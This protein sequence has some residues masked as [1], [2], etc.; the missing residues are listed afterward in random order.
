MTPQVQHFESLP[1][2]SWVALGFHLTPLGYILVSFLEAL[3]LSGPILAIRAICWK[4][5]ALSATELEPLWHP[6]F[7]HATSITKLKK[8]DKWVSRKPS[9]KKHH[10]TS[11]KVAQCG[12][13]D[14]ITI[15]FERSSHARFGGFVITVGYPFWNHAWSLKI[16]DT[17]KV[18]EKIYWG[19]AGGSVGG[20]CGPDKGYLKQTTTPHLP[21]PW[22]TGPQTQSPRPLNNRT[23]RPQTPFH[24]Q[25]TGGP[26]LPTCTTTYIIKRQAEIGCMWLTQPPTRHIKEILK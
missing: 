25:E 18:I 11:P 19:H 3:E 10:P 17:K 20:L 8:R 6:F 23:A 1:Y 26:H 9:R 7:G 16:F 24:R 15:C 2:K 14:I 21:D 13:H 12:T 22:S 5:V 4:W